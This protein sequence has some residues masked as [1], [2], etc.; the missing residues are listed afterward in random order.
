MA[1]IVTGTITDV[2]QSHVE[3]IAAN[4]Y[5]AVDQSETAIHNMIDEA[6]GLY[7]HTIFKLR[8]LG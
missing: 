3:W 6:V 1:A 8:R 5:Q 2:L 4:R 7:Q